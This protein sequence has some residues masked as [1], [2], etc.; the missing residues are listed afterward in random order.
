MGDDV[1][2]NIF[3]GTAW[4]LLLLLA[5]DLLT[6]CATKKPEP[7]PV[8]EIAEPAAEIVA[9]RTETVIVF[10]LNLRS[11]PSAHSKILG[12][13][14][15]GDVVEIQEHRGNWAKVLT[16]EKREGWVLAPGSLSGFARP[17]VRKKPALKKEQ[18]PVRD[19]RAAQQQPGSAAE[20]EPAAE[21]HGATG[22]D[23]KPGAGVATGAG[24]GPADSAGSGHE[25]AAQGPDQSKGVDREMIFI[26]I[27]P[28]RQPGDQRKHN[29]RSQQDVQAGS[30]ARPGAPPESNPPSA[31]AAA[32]DADPANMGAA[33]AAGPGGPP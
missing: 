16:P 18:E 11:E 21:P 33:R 4:V 6:S 32:P 17:S 5:A 10:R 20:R 2:K 26:E 12:L 31:D 1:R 25:V 28:S 19:Q 30:K 15:Q 23:G 14:N 24:A 8:V 22:S 13:L 9:P 27:V 29:G 7:P 3:A